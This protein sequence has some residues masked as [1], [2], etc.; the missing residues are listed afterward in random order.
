MTLRET[1]AA[2]YTHVLGSP[3]QALE[4]QAPE[5]GTLLLLEYRELPVRKS[6]TVL[7]AGL[8]DVLSPPDGNELLFT[9]YERDYGDAARALVASLADALADAGRRHD[10]R[11][12]YGSVLGPRGPILPGTAMTSL[13]AMPLWFHDGRLGEFHVAEGHITVYWLVPLYDEEGKWVDTHGYVEFAKRLRKLDPDVLDL[14]RP[15]L[16]LA[17]TPLSLWDKLK[18]RWT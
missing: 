13:L 11:L 10:A 5:A 8:S 7:T 9:F 14:Q 3:A 4:Y 16:D 17:N 12:D 6:V 1:V 18:R 2:H 15:P